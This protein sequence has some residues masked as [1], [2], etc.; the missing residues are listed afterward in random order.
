MIT[1]RKPSA[2]VP[3]AEA[4]TGSRVLLAC[5]IVALLAIALAIAVR[6]APET[7]IALY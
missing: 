4:I 6:W 3:V 2:E 5:V 7:T 1:G